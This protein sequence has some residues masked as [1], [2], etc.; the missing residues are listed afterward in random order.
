M[1]LGSILSAWKRIDNEAKIQLACP[2][3]PM[4]LAGLLLMFMFDKSYAL[5]AVSA[6]AFIGCAFSELIIGLSILSEFR[7]S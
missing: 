5:R 4:I 6:I 3:L 2:L 7:C 1:G